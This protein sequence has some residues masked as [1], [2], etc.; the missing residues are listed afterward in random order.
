M[1]SNGEEKRTHVQKTWHKLLI[2][3]GS[4][5]YTNSTHEYTLSIPLIAHSNT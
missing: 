4:Q 2:E 5:T 1:F 3:N